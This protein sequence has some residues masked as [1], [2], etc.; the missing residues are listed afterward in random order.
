MERCK[1]DLKDK[2]DFSGYLLIDSLIEI[3]EIFCLLIDS[4][5]TS[6]DLISGFTWYSL[7][8]TFAFGVA[9][10]TLL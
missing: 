1:S 4:T 8:D 7:S 10:G 2:P 3:V 6:I 5:N 9:I